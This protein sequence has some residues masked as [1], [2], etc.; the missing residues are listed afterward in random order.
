M[1]YFTTM[2][3][4]CEKGGKPAAWELFHTGDYIAIGWCYDTD[5]TGKSMEEIRPLV[6]ETA[7]NENDERDRGT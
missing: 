2:S 1:P 7:Y 4:T 5:L 6:R 3:P